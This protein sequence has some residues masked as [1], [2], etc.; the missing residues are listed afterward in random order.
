MA[1]SKIIMKAELNSISNK[2]FLIKFATF[3]SK[4]SMVCYT[5]LRTFSVKLRYN[6][7]NLKIKVYISASIHLY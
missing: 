1:N 5:K 2:I 4:M 7:P 6:S 3:D